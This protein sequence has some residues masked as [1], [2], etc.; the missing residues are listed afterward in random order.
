MKTPWMVNHNYYTPFGGY[1]QTTTPRKG[2]GGNTMD[3]LHDA[4]TRLDALTKRSATLAGEMYK[5]C[6]G[7]AQVQQEIRTLIETEKK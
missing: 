2:Q 3:K 7:I 1:S 4:Y 6:R 5:V